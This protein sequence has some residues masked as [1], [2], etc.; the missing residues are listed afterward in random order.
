MGIERLYIPNNEM[1]LSVLRNDYLIDVEGLSLLNIGSSIIYDVMAKD[2]KPYVF[3]LLQSKYSIND[4]NR[5]FDVSVF[6]RKNNFEVPEYKYTISNQKYSTIENYKAF[7]MEKLKGAVKRE[8]TGSRKNLI[9][10]SEYYGKVITV[11]ENCPSVFPSPPQGK[12]IIDDLEDICAKLS[13][14]GER[15]NDKRVSDIIY[16]KIELLNN[17]CYD[18][19]YADLTY[20]NST[21]DFTHFQ[22][23]YDENED[24]CGLLDFES[25]RK[26]PVVYELFRSF[27]FMTENY[28]QKT[29]EFDYSELLDYI[30]T[31]CSF[32]KLTNI[33]IK[34]FFYPFYIEMLKSVFGFEC[35]GNDDRE[36]K[37]KE[38]GLDVF[39]K[40]SFLSRIITDFSQKLL[41][42]LC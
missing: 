18:N 40:C 1:V 7:L 3:K 5:A 39:R 22:L 8:N 34:Y 9:E 38:I 29:G 11:L 14:F 33:D 6:L 28:N 37:A 17:I 15:S 10:L 20:K 32:Q 24:I 36:I 2:G 25:S 4:L 31:Y 19:D 23:L 27:I 13:G 41:N 35:L 12:Y 16:K 30:K 21:G 26:M 42:D